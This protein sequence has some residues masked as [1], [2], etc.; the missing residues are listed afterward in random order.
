M[1]LHGSLASGIIL[2]RV[3]KSRICLHSCRPQSRSSR[4]RSAASAYAR[5]SLRQRRRIRQLRESRDSWKTET[6]I[7]A[8]CVVSLWVLKA[9]RLSSKYRARTQLF[10]LQLSLHSWRLETKKTTAVTFSRSSST[11]LTKSFDHT[12]TPIWVDQIRRWSVSNAVTTSKRAMGHPSHL[13]SKRLWLSRGSRVKASLTTAQ[14]MVPNYC[15]KKS[16][17]SS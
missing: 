12:S 16:R 14:T 13:S 3:A 7:F 9:T 6:A 8:A 15:S 4:T 10:F 2:K 17:M 11:L 1:R 5:R